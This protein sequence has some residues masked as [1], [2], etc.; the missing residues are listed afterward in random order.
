MTREKWFKT[1]AGRRKI[2]ELL[3]GRKRDKAQVCPI[4]IKDRDRDLVALK[5][6][7]TKPA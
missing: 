2:R 5:A 3:A 1:Q 4:P 6:P 7:R